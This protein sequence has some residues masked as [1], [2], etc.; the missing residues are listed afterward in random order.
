MPHK[1]TVPRIIEILKDVFKG[2]PF[3][4]FYDGDPELIPDF[5]LPCICV[6]K[7]GD[8]TDIETS[9]SDQVV[10][11]V[12]IKVVYDKRDDWTADVDPLDMTEKKIRDII[13]KIDETTGHYETTT[14]KSALREHLDEQNMVLDDEMTVALGINPRSAE[15]LTAEGHVT[16]TVKYSVNIQ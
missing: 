16:I 10:E 7:L 12:I 5:N 15:L 14:I 4:E 9:A 11:Q 1:D 3:K 6:S 13:G 2:G 8:S